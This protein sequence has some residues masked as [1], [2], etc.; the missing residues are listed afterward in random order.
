M[1]EYKE[2]IIKELLAD[3]YPTGALININVYEGEFTCCIDIDELLD[4]NAT[5]TFQDLI[6]TASEVIFDEVQHQTIIG[7]SS[8][9]I[10]EITLA[11]AIHFY[12]EQFDIDV[13]HW[14]GKESMVKLVEEAFGYPR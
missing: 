2:E 3:L 9:D 6:D 10:R 13:L 12:K 7:A 1:N 11:M 5:S 4:N 8:S 14:N